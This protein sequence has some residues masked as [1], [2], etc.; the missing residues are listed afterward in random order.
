[1]SSHPLETNEFLG[2]IRCWNVVAPSPA[3]GTWVPTSIKVK[4]FVTRQDCPLSCKKCAQSLTAESVVR[5]GFIADASDTMHTIGYNTRTG[6]RVTHKEFPWVC[7]RP[8]LKDRCKLDM[9]KS[10]VNA[11]GRGCAPRSRRTSKKGGKVACGYQCT[12]AHSELE[13]Q[14]WNRCSTIGV[15][16]YSLSEPRIQILKDDLKQLK[17]DSNIS[18]LEGGLRFEGCPRKQLSKSSFNTVFFTSANLCVSLGADNLH[19]L[20]LITNNSTKFETSLVFDSLGVC[21]IDAACVLKTNKHFA[22]VVN[23]L[24]K[25]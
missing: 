21:L 15:V 24:I 12:S 13:L 10:A 7:L 2:C 23:N 20:R 8:F 19:F 17:L 14:Y 5:I 1:M 6:A 25:N 4:S 3:S 16:G 22:V 18:L 11:K 9:C